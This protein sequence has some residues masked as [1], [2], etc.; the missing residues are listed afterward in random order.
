ME[1]LVD[2]LGVLS[3]AFGYGG[4]DEGGE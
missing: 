2:H 3:V 4:E 1:F